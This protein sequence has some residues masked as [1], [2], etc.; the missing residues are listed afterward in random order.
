M[1]ALRHL[2]A[3]LRYTRSELSK[4]SGVSERELARIEEN[5]VVPTKDT[6]G[7]ID[8]AIDAEIHRRAGSAESE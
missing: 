7:R 5:A 6:V 8:I 2:R 3:I 4:A 1:R